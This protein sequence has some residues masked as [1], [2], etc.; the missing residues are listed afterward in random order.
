ML[1]TRSLVALTLS[2]LAVYGVKARQETWA[3]LYLEPRNRR[4]LDQTRSK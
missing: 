1:L 4:T 3:K 2:V